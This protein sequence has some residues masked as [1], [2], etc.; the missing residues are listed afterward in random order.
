LK[1]S[2]PVTESVAETPLDVGSGGQEKG[3]AFG[4]L[5]AGFRLRGNS[6]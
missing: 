3:G 2:E 1:K 6:V 5:R 4:R